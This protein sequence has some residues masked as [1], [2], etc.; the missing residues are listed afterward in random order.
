VRARGHADADQFK[1]ILAERGD[2]HLILSIE[3]E[4]GRNANVYAK[5]IDSTK[6]LV[7]EP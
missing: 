3:P 7:V 4:A 6:G 2:E 5:K 1:G